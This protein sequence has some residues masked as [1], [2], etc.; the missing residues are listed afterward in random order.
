M[1][2]EPIAL[3]Q[4]ETLPEAERQPLNKSCSHCGGRQVLSG[5]FDYDG[6]RY[7]IYLPGSCRCWKTE[8]ITERIRQ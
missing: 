8:T 5:Y 6:L 1:S 2:D 7:W 4:P 3:K